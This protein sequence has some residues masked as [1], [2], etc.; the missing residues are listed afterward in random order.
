MLFVKD[1]HNYRA[2]ECMMNRNIFQRNSLWLT[3]NNYTHG[4]IFWNLTP[5]NKN[6]DNMTN[7][8]LICFVL[9]FKSITKFYFT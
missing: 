8:V 4:D 7:G 6:K 3:V 1:S 2:I 5:S 9:F